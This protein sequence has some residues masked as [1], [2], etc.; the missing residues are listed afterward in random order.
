M[1]I[2]LSKILQSNDQIRELSF[3]TLKITSPVLFFPLVF[4][5]IGL[6]PD[7]KFF[8]GAFVIALIGFN[9]YT[10]LL[11]KPYSYLAVPL[12]IITNGIT[13]LGLHII[14]NKGLA[15]VE[16]KG[17]I[18]WRPQDR[19]ILTILKQSMPTPKRIITYSQNRIYKYGAPYTLFG[20]FF[21]LNFV[22]PYFMWTHDSGT[23]YNLM[24]MLR[25]VGGIL[26]SL[27]IVRQKWAQRLL[28]YLPTFWHLT[29][30]YCIPFTSTVM[31]LLTQ[32]SVEWLINVAITIMFLIVLV[33]W[34]TFLLLAI[35]GVG[36]GCLFYRL[37]IGPIDL[38]LDFTTGY[39]L[40]Y[41][42]TFSTLICLLFARRRQQ[43]FERRLQDMA[44]HCSD[45]M[46]GLEASFSRAAVMR[47]AQR[48][49][50][51]VGDFIESNAYL[52]AASIPQHLAKSQQTSAEQFI[53]FFKYFRP[54]AH[55]FVRQGVHMQELLV[56][57]LRV[58]VIAPKIERLSMRD[59]VRPVVDG[60]FF[61]TSTCR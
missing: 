57:A 3:L 39:L 26:A 48:I 34:L 47:L 55:E 9:I 41:A 1:G 50:K 24:F 43:F 18:Q 32:G 19:S 44:T 29:L 53:D 33:D 22:L 28:P 37:A 36:L 20:V 11:P 16:R 51:Q 8:Y 54:T 60:F 31:F 6:K 23:R 45:A 17:E 46:R 35:L 42:V 12:A 2:K 30:L 59:C 52:Q 4:G 14:Q 56:E 15:I 21:V 25:L 61:S 5:I 10:W 27:L 40:V 13:F 58:H 7:K 49:D 38:Q